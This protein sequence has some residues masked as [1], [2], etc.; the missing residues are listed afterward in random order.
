MTV[1]E[2]CN[3]LRPEENGDLPV[4]VRARWHGESP[5]HDE[6]SVDNAVAHMDAD[7]AEDEMVILA[8]QD[9]V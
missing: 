5:A 9:G 8:S 1:R 4:I 2:L 3:A 7:T 6:F